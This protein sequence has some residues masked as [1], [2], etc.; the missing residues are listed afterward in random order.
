MT[1][2]PRHKRPDGDPLAL[3]CAALG[4]FDADRAHGSEALAAELELLEPT[5]CRDEIENRVA[6][7]ADRERLGRRIAAVETER[8]HLLRQRELGMLVSPRELATLDDIER[9]LRVKLAAAGD[10]S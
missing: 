5:L 3:A 1:E 7:A 10:A 2:G 4:Y 6:D 9:S 8:R